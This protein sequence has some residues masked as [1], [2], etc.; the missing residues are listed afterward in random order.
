MLRPAQIPT[1][2]RTGGN[3]DEVATFQL[4]NLFESD[5]LL[6]DVPAD[7]PEGSKTG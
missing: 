4:N 5:A 3:L 7:D 1:P 2:S 6:L